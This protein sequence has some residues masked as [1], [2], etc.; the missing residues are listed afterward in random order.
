[1][2]VGRV[3][4]GLAAVACAPTRAWARSAARRCGSSCSAPPSRWRRTSAMSSGGEEVRRA[5]R[6]VE[7]AD[8]PGVG[9]RGTQRPSA[10]GGRGA[11][12]ASRSPRCSTSPARS[13]RPPWPPNRPRVKVRAAAE[14]GGHVEAAAH[15]QVGAAARRRRRA[16][17]AQHAARPRRRRALPARHRRAVER[18]R[19]VGAGRARS[20]AS[21]WNRSVGPVTVHLERRA[22]RR[23]C[24]PA[25]WRAGTTARPSAPTAARRR[26]SS[27][28]ARASP[29]RWSACPASSTS[30]AA[31]AVRAARRAGAVWTAPAANAGRVE[32]PA[33]R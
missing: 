5:V 8:L 13:A 31:A 9:Q 2:D 33:R 6:A 22:R 12:A 30:I 23:R 1:M 19:H 14:I 15:G 24:R 20:T 18:R 17:S 4:P 3:Q 11:V 27:R 26:P 10:R 28:G 25:G 21:A 29:A 7:H 16:P 32:R